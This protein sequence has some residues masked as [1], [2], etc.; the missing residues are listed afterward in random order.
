MA[1]RQSGFA[2]HSIAMKTRSIQILAAVLTL[3]ARPFFAVEQTHPLG[4]DG[5]DNTQS[6]Y[7]KVTG[8]DST[9]D[10]FPLKSTNV[11]ADIS[12][13]IADVEVEQAYTNSGKVPIEAVY[14]FPASTRAAVHGVEMRIGQ[15]V[16]VSKIAEKAEAKQT[17]EKAKSEKKTASLLEQQRPNVFQ[18]SIANIAPGEEVR[19]RLHYSE[20]LAA[21]D[22]TYEFMYPTVVG[23]RYS[24]KGA[25]T[26]KW[27]QNPYL[28]EGTGSPTTFAINVN[29]RAGMPLQS[30]TS[31]SHEAAIAFHGKDNATAS[32]TS[33]SKHANRDF[34]LRYRLAD[35]A[36]TSGLLLHQGKD[37]NFFLL[38]V[39]PPARVKASQVTPRDY[40]FILD[41]SGSMNGFPI[42]TGKT[43]MVDLLK[44][45]NEQ[46]TFNVL[47]FAGTSAA[48]SDKPLPA[49]LANIDR[50]VNMTSGARAAGG[51]ELLPALKHAYSLPRRDGVSRSIVVITDGYVSIEKEAYAL[52]RNNLN[53]GNVFAFGIGSA[54]NRHLIESMAR[55]GQ[56][57][58]FVVSDPAQARVAAEHFRHYVSSPVLTNLEVTYDG[59]TASDAQPQSLPD[60]FAD[61]SIELIGKWKGEAKGR[62]HLKGKAGNAPYEAT[63]D[64]ASEAARGM[65]NPALRPLWARERVR[66]LSDDEAVRPDAETT[67]EITSLG[68]TYS[69]LTEHTSFVGVDETPKELLAAAQTVNQAL[70]LPQGVTDMAVGGQ[71]A[72]TIAAA[73]STPEPSVMGLLIMGLSALALHRRRAR[74]I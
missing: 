51:T 65:S 71:P 67:R 21:R 54:V 44:S 30:L 19:V 10:A 48:L 69:L 74:R 66:A 57:E 8:A 59:F 38:N 49:T 14:V 40:V 18:M 4:A 37:E 25:S 1:R 33:D 28:P 11:K 50:G 52:V 62:I 41:V 35:E 47:H 70:P 27:M 15:R 39:Q 9:T 68:L 55:A 58:V 22:R 3:V 34:I 26:E 17:F 53:K 63:F 56:G 31:P 12:G 2:I 36:V 61:R 6:P 7:F 60:V 5:P 32:L 23:P 42:Q 43:L 64:V 72:P 20:K 29:V 45:L 13:V 46:D 24:N 16:I 73:G